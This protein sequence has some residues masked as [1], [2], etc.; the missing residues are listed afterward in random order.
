MGVVDYEQDA[1]FAGRSS[2][3]LRRL[4][5][6]AVAGVFFQ[7]TAA[8]SWIVSLGFAFALSGLALAAYFVW[9]RLARSTLPGWTS[10]AVLI[11]V[12]TGAILV[13]VG[14]IGLYVGRVFEEAK[15]RPLYVV[16]S[17]AERVAQW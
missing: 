14:I 4:V 12:S 2:Y 6:H 3:T 16:D 15:Q 13:C 7:T 5:R 17:V 11:L 8:L 1:R 10:L 9:E